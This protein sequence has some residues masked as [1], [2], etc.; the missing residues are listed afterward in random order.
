MLSTIATSHTL[1]NC[2]AVREQLQ[3]QL[4]VCLVWRYNRHLGIAATVQLLVNIR[5]QSADS[6]SARVGSGLSDLSYEPMGTDV[7]CRANRPKYH[8]A[9]DT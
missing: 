8:R 9:P 6:E 3:T 1:S 2:L 4:A 5:G 7:T